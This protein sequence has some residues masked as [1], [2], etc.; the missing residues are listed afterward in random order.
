M[1][2]GAPDAIVDGNELAGKM[3][4]YERRGVDWVEHG[5]SALFVG[6]NALNTFGLSVFLNVDGSILAISDQ[7]YLEKFS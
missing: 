7:L 1:A 6:R 3:Q 2:V 4:V 5:P